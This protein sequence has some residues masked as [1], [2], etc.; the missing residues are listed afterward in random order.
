MGENN[1]KMSK[2][3]EMLLTCPPEFESL[4]TPLMDQV[5]K[6]VEFVLKFIDWR[7]KTENLVLILQIL[8]V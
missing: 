1:R 5:Q 4:A 3:E 7:V 6:S 2:N 8:F